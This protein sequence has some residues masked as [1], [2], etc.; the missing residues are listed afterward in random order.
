MPC[1]VCKGQRESCLTCSDPKDPQRRARRVVWFDRCPTALWES[2]VGRFIAS[3]FRY[4]DGFL[5]V[6]GG[7][8]DQ[9]H[10]WIEALKV[11]LPH[12]RECERIAADRAAKSPR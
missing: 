9:A 11:A 7:M 2:W 8:L 5:P 4:R 6:A 1:W 3:V 12:L 10:V